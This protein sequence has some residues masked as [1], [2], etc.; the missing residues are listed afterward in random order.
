MRVAARSLSHVDACNPLLQAHPTWARDKHEGRGI[1]TSLS[2]RLPFPPF[3]LH[4]APT[5]LGW[6]TRRQFT[7]RSRD[8]PGGRNTDTWSETTTTGQTDFL[9]VQILVPF[10][11]KACLVYSKTSRAWQPRPLAIGELF[12]S[13]KICGIRASWLS[14]TRNYFL[15]LATPNSLSKMLSKKST[16]LSCFSSLCLCKPTSNI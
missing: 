15:L 16:Y 2:L 1:S 10:G 14:N 3:A 8:P 4:L 11:G 12:F 6:G 13:G 9:V 5:H 7:R